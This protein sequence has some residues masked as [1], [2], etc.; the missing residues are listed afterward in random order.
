MKLF[1]VMQSSNGVKVTLTAC[2]GTDDRVMTRPVHTS[3][4]HMTASYTTQRPRETDEAF[5]SFF[6]GHYTCLVTWPICC[7]YKTNTSTNVSSME[8]KWGQNF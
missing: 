4:C 6:V 3:C 1:V 2:C 8:P 7:F 5:F